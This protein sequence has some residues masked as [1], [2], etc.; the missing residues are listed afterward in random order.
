MRDWSRTTGALEWVR[1]VV[2]W[3]HGWCHGAM[4]GVERNVTAVVR[5]HILLALPL[6]LSPD[7]LDYWH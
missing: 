3:C 2:P 6:L 5:R 4:G 1:V 7:H